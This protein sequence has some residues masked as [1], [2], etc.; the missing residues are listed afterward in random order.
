[1]PRA[2]N[3]KPGICMN[4]E[5]AELSCRH[6]FLFAVLPCFADREGR[7]EDRPLRIKMQVFP[8]DN[9]DMDELL[10]D[11]HRTSM[12]QRYEVNNCK[13][14][15]IVNFSKHQNPHRDEKP[16]EIPPPPKH[17]VSTEQ[18][19]CKHSTNRAD[20]LNLIPDSFNPHPDSLNSVPDGTGADAPTTP[21]LW[22]V[23]TQQLAIERSLIGKWIKDY[24]EEKVATAIAAA[25]L[26]RPA[27]PRQW[28][29]AY[30]QDRRSKTSD[31][32]KEKA[33]EMLF[34]SS[35][36]GESRRIV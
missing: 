6:R 12:V 11:L 24:S 32:V 13:Y 2:R 8:A 31:E 27:D 36:E 4:E 7:L 30:L 23:G 3:I 18:A 15:Q 25:S 1:M 5:L 10:Q 14:I 26:K 22:D 34:G 29:T 35:F 20:S 28:I 16:S 17:D 21:T 33:R 9:C 19:P